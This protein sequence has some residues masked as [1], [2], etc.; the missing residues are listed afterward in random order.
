MTP[1]S[2]IFGIAAVEM[3]IVLPIVLLLLVPIGELGRAFIQ[4]SRLSH[5]IEAGARHVADNVLQG[6]TGVPVLTE[7]LREQARRLVVYGSTRS[8][9]IDPPAVPGLLTG[10]I[11]VTV[12]TGGVV[13]VSTDY[14]YQPVVGA[15]LPMLGFG[16]DIDISNLTLRPRA[17]MRAL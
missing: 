12:S 7:A 3:A 9:A 6:S 4:Y 14:V 5:R 8:P 17:V 15:V 10:D 1:R 2:R 16:S 13:T 11:V